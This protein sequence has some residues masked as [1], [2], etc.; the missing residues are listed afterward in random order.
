MTHVTKI[1]QDGQDG[2]DQIKQISC[3]SCLIL[4]VLILFLSFLPIY[5]ED[6][7]VV[8]LATENQL[9]ALYLAP[10]NASDSGFDSSYLNKL[11]NVLRF[12]LNYNGMTCLSADQN[13]PYRVKIS[14]NN[15]QLSARISFAENVKSMNSIP[16]SGSL[17]EDRRQIHILSDAIYKAFFNRE[18]IACSHL[19]YTLK[20]QNPQTKK[21]ISEVFETDYDGGNAHQVTKQGAYCVTPCYFPAKQ[22]FLT[23]SFAFVSYEIGQPKIY[24]GSLDQAKHQRFSLLRGNQ[25]M[26]AF[27]QQRDQI[28]FIS[29]VTGNPDLFLQAFDAEKGPI[30]KPRQIFSAHLATQAS[31]TF[32][33]DGKS[34]A[35]V[36]N[37][38]GSTRIYVI[39]IPEAGAK[40]KDIKANL[41]TKQNW[42]SS[43]PC[44][45]P[46]GKKIA[47]CAMTKGVRQIW[48]YDFDQKRERQVTHG[49][50][51]KENPFFA[52]NSLHL[53][54]NCENE[55]YIINLNQNEAVKITAGP[56]AKHFP[57]WEP[58]LTKSS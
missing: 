21:W 50:G 14:I 28:A 22:G 27:S 35:F 38:D 2:Q 29:D 25:L 6:P 13:A 49:S 33:P 4:N 58:R 24:Y 34:I 9:S 47:Y 53:V 51:N 19:L 18:G 36:S 48:I 12:D 10:F 42:E 55:L 44:W 3:P 7:I 46:D 8:E 11:E 1:N 26:P 5:A 54:Y 45:S 32:S 23:R 39:K 41:L 37:K 56:G 30:G 15:K 17:A 57:V 31:P 52:P 20:T 16:L 43:A 40:L